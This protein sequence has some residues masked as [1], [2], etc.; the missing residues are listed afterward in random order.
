LITAPPEGAFLGI[1]YSD[2]ARF[3]V[4]GTGLRNV[5]L[6]SAHNPSIIYGRFTI[7]N[8]GTQ[9]LL[10]WDFYANSY[11]SYLVRI[12]AWDVPPGQAGRQI[13]VMA[14]RNYSVHLP[15]GCQGEGTCGGTAP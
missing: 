4:S 10:G 11:G 1:D 8:D 9:A 13:E 14:P 7:S 6:V 3:Q 2:P 12:L 5:E 15:L